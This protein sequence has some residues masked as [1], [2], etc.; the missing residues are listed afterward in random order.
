MPDEYMLKQERIQLLAYHAK[1]MQEYQDADFVL[2]TA[3]RVRQLATEL[4]EAAESR[5]AEA[6]RKAA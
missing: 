6:T 5:L 3:T 1:R 4:C 2:R